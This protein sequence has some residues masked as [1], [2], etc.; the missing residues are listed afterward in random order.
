MASHNFNCDFK[1]D[2]QKAMPKAFLPSFKQATSAYNQTLNNPPQNIIFSRKTEGI[3]I[4]TTL[5]REDA[6]RLENSS[7]TYQYGPHNKFEAR[8]KL[9]KQSPF[10]FHTNPK[11][12]YIDWIMDSGLRYAKNSDLD[13]WLSRYVTVIKGCEDDNDRDTAFMN[14]M[15]RAYVDFNKS[16]E[17]DRFTSIEID[18]TLPNGQIQ[19][20]K[21]KVKITYKD[22]PVFCR[23]CQKDHIG[24]CPVRQQEEA[25]E[26]IE[27]ATRQPQ[28]KTLMCGE[29]NLRYVNQTGTTAKVV[30]ATGAKIGHIANMIAHEEVA[31]YKRIVIHGGQNNII[32]S[33]EIETVHFEK[34][35]KIE[36]SRLK[37]ALESF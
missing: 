28:I 23:R 13:A 34:Q 17:I 20:C 31:K 12:I 29:S 30:V 16:R 18:V 26:E 8:I 35:L 32:A 33:E 24:F 15:K 21:A 11:N 22:Q 10:I 36:F 3:F 4:I 2:F 25:A 1:L 5:S 27:E 14:G 37:K 9:E 19:P 7:I 6:N